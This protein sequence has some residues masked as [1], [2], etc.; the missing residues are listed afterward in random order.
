MDELT[1]QIV[2]GI[3]NA[4]IAVWAARTGKPPGWRPSPDEWSELA[5]LP[6][7]EEIKARK[8]T[9]SRVAE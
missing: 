7:L 8:I 2:V 3:I 4:A 5:K 6:T 1:K 9:P